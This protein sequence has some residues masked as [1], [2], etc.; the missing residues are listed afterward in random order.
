MKILGARLAGIHYMIY[1]HIC[2]L[3][4]QY[5]LLKV[6]V[7]L[8]IL[9]SRRLFSFRLWFH[10]VRGHQTWIDFRSSI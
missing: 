5:K 10:P 6:R 4:S 8:Q 7:S 3:K 2:S 1:A 9:V